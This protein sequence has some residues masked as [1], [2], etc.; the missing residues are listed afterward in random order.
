MT[1]LPLW[2][3]RAVRRLRMLLLLSLALVPALLV[4]ACGSGSGSDEF[5]SDDLKPLSVADDFTVS[6]PGTPDREPVTVPTVAGNAK[7]VV[8]TVK[9]DDEAY[10]VASTELPA[11]G[12]FDL[13]ASIQGSATGVQ[14]TVRNKK[15]LRYQGYP[16]RDALLANAKS[17]GETVTVFIRA[18][19][20]KESNRVRLFQLQ[21]VS[22]DADRTSAPALYDEFMA[23]LK[24]K[25]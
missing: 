23:S 20:V 6:M 3:D 5:T 8:Y 24:I 18:I 9:N 17:Q 21:H 16:A 15:T 4:A 22:R 19:V 11:G 10:V 13:D 14:G 12:Q 7:G 1:G 25:P 2:K